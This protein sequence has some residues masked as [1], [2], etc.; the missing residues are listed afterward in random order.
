M[1]IWGIVKDVRGYPVANASVQRYYPTGE[2]YSSVIVSGDS[3]LFNGRV[4]NDLHYWLVSAP[5]YLPRPISLEGLATNDI[6]APVLVTL[7]DDPLLTAAVQPRPSMPDLS[8]SAAPLLWG[9][10]GAAVA[11][12]GLWYIGGNRDKVKMRK[13]FK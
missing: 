13:I 4:P 10:G 6:T 8:M 2:V 3:G 12:A 5:G 1:E 7:E 9:V 11:A